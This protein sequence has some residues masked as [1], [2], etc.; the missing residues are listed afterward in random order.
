MKKRILTLCVIIS[1]TIV[2]AHAT[3]IGQFIANMVPYKIMIDGV[4]EQFEKPVV[5]INGSTYIAVRELCEKLG[6]YIER[7]EKEKEVVINTDEE[8]CV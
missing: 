4:E 3:E 8:R 5:N 2:L 6:V 1:M 7:K